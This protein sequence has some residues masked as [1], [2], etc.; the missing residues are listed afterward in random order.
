MAQKYCLNLGCGNDYRITDEERHW[1]NVDSG[2][3]K[4]DQALDIEDTPWLAEFEEPFDEIYAIQVLEHISKDKFANVIREMYK[5]S[6]D[7]AVWHI[8]VPHGF[9]DNFITD[10]THRMP[11]S[12]R[13]FDYFVDGSQLRE[14]GIIYGWGD[15]HLVH[16]EPPRI[17]GNQSIIFTL[18]VKK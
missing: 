12:T 16:L 9:S 8:A 18:G 17:D 6:E 4:V 3:C 5:Y 13:T 1:E 11:F 15:I 14:N 10:P 2:Q 7:G